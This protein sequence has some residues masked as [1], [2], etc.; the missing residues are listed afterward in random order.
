MLS[1][2]AA[3]N[4][5]VAWT[6]AIS[7]DVFKEEQRKSIASGPEGRLTVRRYSR[8]G[9]VFVVCR[10]QHGARDASLS[11]D[12]HPSELLPYWSGFS[13]P[14]EEFRSDPQMSWWSTADARGWPL[15]TLWSEPL[16]GA[17]SGGK[18]EHRPSQ[19]GI[20]TPLPCWQP[21]WAYPPP[22]ILP[23][24]PI[25]SGFLANTAGYSL[26]CFTLIRGP[27][28]L[29]RRLR[30]KRGWCPFCGYPIGGSPECT[31]CGNP[32]PLT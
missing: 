10:R 21:T 31:E 4:V 24:R 17:V 23:L 5:L 12:V 11:G 28:V 1:A 6:L 16:G 25:W 13:V 20:V 18:P 27:Q 3:I 15:L 32:I 26:L 29:R 14:A 7:V 9:G 2:G 30:L 19:G 8:L 22:R